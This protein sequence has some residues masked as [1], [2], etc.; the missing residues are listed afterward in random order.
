MPTRILGRG[1][2]YF[3]PFAVGTQDPTGFRHFGN[4]PEFSLSMSPSNLEHYDSDER[5]RVKDDD[6][7]LEIKRSGSFK[8]DNMSAENRALFFMGDV[9]T[10]S[11][12]SGTGVSYVVQDATV[13]RYY[14]LGASIS[15]P[16][17]H[18][19]VSSVASAG[20]TAPADF[21]VVDADRGL[22]YIPAGST[23]TGDTTFTYN[24]AVSTR[25]QVATSQDVT[26]EGE[27][28]FVAAAGNG[29]ANDV[30]YYMPRVKLT[31]TGDFAL[32]GDSWQEMNFNV[33][34]LSKTGYAQMYIDGRP[35]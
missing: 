21:Q 31:P 17:G 10:I 22:I 6:V 9:D 15:N 23:I 8:T 30:D 32:K 1:K 28:L 4:T 18:K 34:I 25:E 16:T 14:Q 5:V 3:S 33:E 2:L 26:I 12:S 19:K 24:H 20:K 35:T 13:G 11:Q 7:L 27:L 29:Q